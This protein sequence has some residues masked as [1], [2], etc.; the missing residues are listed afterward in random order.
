MKSSGCWLNTSKV[1]R[2]IDPVA[3]NNKIFRGFLSSA[4][5]TSCIFQYFLSL[6]RYFISIYISL[7]LCP[8]ISILPVFR[9]FLYF[10]ISVKS[11]CFRCHFI[12]LDRIL[13]KIVFK[14]KKEIHTMMGH[15]MNLFSYLRKI[16]HFIQISFNF[17]FYLSRLSISIRL[18]EVRLPADSLL[19]SVQIP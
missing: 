2:P 19:C 17:P 16:K 6:Y 9:Y 18:R 13:C 4:I 12:N 11:G 10:H 3:P 8:C 1:C 7:F 5:V 15:E 14:K